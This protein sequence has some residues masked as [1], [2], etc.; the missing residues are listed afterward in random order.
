MHNLQN[1]VLLVPS[2]IVPPYKQYGVSIQCLAESGDSPESN[3]VAAGN[4]AVT[5]AISC[6]SLV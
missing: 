3:T 6:F 2:S 5:V 4:V 1:G